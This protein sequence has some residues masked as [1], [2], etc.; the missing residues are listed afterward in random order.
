MLFHVFHI[1]MQRAD[2]RLISGQRRLIG[3]IASRKNATDR[4]IIHPI[5]LLCE[6]EITIYLFSLSSAERWPFFRWL[7][8]ELVKSQHYKLKYEYYKISIKAEFSNKSF[9]KKV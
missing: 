1:L 3:M 2:R 7:H 6:A 4:L 5:K 9:R 8:C